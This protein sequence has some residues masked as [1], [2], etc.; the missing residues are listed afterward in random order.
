[1]STDLENS[2]LRERLQET[3]QQHFSQLL[4]ARATEGFDDTELQNIVT[5]LASVIPF[6]NASLARIREQLAEKTSTDEMLE[7]LNKVWQ[8][9]YTLR[10]DTLGE[11][12]LRDIELYVYLSALDEQW[13][14]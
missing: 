9:T 1:E 14:N 3:F 2:N 6:D 7:L 5:E 11:V 4:A 12:L 10:K 13:M 8:D